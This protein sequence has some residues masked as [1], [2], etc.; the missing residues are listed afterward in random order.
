MGF[1][2]F[3]VKMEERVAK[4]LQKQVMTIISSTACIRCVEA[5]VAH[6][7]N[8]LVLPSSGAKIPYVLKH[9]KIVKQ[10]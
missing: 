4:P 7:S 8:L 1:V 10:F 9:I 2:I 3:T 6:V 5:C